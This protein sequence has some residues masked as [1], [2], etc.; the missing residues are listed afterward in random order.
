[1][2]DLTLFLTLFSCVCRDRLS[3]YVFL[4]TRELYK[5]YV[6]ETIIIP[7]YNDVDEQIDHVS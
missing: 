6:K 3:N 7:Q 2:T 4:L 5:H 1:M